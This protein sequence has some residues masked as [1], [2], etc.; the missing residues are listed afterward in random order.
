MSRSSA[1]E[2]G[3]ESRLF[4]CAVFNRLIA[5]G[6]ARTDR[7]FQRNIPDAANAEK[8][9]IVG[10]KIALPFATIHRLEPPGRLTL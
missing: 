6:E 7:F 8:R 4:L 5:I 9:R 2:K 10:I 1:D 3:G